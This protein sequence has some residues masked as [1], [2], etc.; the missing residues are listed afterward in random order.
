MDIADLKRLPTSTVVDFGPA[1]ELNVTWDPSLLTP[2]VRTQLESG[3]MAE[4]A[5]AV[6]DVVTEWDLTIDDEPVEPEA[7]VTTNRVPELIVAQVARQVIAS[8]GDVI[9]PTTDGPHP[10]LKVEEQE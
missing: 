3:A 9:L 7:V 10:E 6:A 1:G 8:L 2:H 5:S 4:V